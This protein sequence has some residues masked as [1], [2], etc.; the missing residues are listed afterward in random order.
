MPATTHTRSPH[1]T[2]T[3]SE[4]HA[5]APKGISSEGLTQGPYVT[6][7]AGFEPAN[8]RTRGDESTN[9]PPRPTIICC[10]CYTSPDHYGPNRI[11]LIPLGPPRAMPGIFSTCHRSSWISS[12]NDISLMFDY[13]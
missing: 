3:A 11:T 6:A 10:L 7:R 2:K 8:L 5:E 13:S 1:S 12:C 9:E 4:F